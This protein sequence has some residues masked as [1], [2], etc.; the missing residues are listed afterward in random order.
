[1]SKL[2]RH[3]DM[4]TGWMPRFLFYGEP[5]Q[6]VVLP[7]KCPW[8]SHSW[9]AE[10]MSSHWNP[11]LLRWSHSDQSAW[12]LCHPQSKSAQTCPQWCLGKK[13]AR[14]S[15]RNSNLKIRSEWKI[16]VWSDSWN[17]S[18]RPLVW[19]GTIYFMAL[20]RIL[21]TTCS[22]CSETWCFAHGMNIKPWAWKC[23]TGECFR[24]SD[25]KGSE[26]STRS[27]K[28]QMDKCGRVSA[29]IILLISSSSPVSEHCKVIYFIVP[30]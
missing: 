5:N 13:K 19:L 17:W 14:Q 22:T 26:R 25:E 2:G 18:V 7:E 15:E 29:G 30:L 11:A 8:Q 12:S 20:K 21:I 6:R 4:Q 27:V 9:E 3:T 28:F 24:D 10:Q 16:R 1:M 23:Y